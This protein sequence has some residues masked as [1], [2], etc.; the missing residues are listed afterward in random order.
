MI[1]G[2]WKFASYTQSGPPRDQFEDFVTVLDISGAQRAL[3]GGGHMPGRRID[4][5][6]LAEVLA[7]GRRLREQR[8][9]G[10]GRPLTVEQSRRERV[11]WLLTQNVTDRQLSA[12]TVSALN[13]SKE[14]LEA[15]ESSEV[16]NGPFF[17]DHRVHLDVYEEISVITS[18][19]RRLEA[20]GPR[21]QRLPPREDSGADEQVW[22]SAMARFAALRDYWNDVSATQEQVKRLEQLEAEPSTRHRMNEALIQTAPDVHSLA[23]LRMLA[24]EARATTEALDEVIRRG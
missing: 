10:D 8:P 18:R 14:L 11:L 19:I 24:A 5:E 23:D 2:I 21:G 15:F 7:D 12:E 17:K 3:E 22:D 16:W 6:G 20:L 1:R 9:R 13:A 4:L